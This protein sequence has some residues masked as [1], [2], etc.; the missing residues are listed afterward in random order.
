M[1]PKNI[2]AT[3]LII[4]YTNS[5]LN[6][7]MVSGIASI[8]SIEGNYNFSGILSSW[9]ATGVIV[10]VNKK[11]TFEAIIAMNEPNSIVTQIT[12]PWLPES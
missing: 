3:E 1:K 5:S 10:L 7:L 4:S 9:K 11:K 12:T 2:P 6:V 8:E